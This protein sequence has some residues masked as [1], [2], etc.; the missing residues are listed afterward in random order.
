MLLKCDGQ[1]LVNEPFENG[2]DVVLSCVDDN[3]DDTAVPHV[4]ETVVEL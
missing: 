1:V 4:N 3:K 2:A